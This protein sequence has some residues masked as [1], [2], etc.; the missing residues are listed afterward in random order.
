MVRRALQVLDHAIPV[1]NYRGGALDQDL[2][3]IEIEAMINL[4]LRVGE[5]GEW[6]LS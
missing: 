5:H 2:G 3:F 4:A 1:Y 6:R